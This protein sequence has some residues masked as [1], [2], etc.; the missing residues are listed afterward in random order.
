MTTTIQR[1]DPS[2]DARPSY[3]TP[4]LERWRSRTDT[5]LVILAI[6][7]LPL[8][9]LELK[10]GDLTFADRLLLDV[11]NIVVLVAFSLDY[12]VELALT[13]DRRQYVRREW[14]SALVVI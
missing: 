9:L 12:V 5:P 4:A 2:I 1:S 14:T 13:R 10:R 8:L 3:M 6:G 7:S 11:V